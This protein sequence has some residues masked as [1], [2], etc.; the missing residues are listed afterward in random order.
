M[1]RQRRGLFQQSALIGAKG[2]ELQGDWQAA[3]EGVLPGSFISLSFDVRSG[4]PA[5]EYV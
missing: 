2:D 5:S 4:I 1:A 3:F